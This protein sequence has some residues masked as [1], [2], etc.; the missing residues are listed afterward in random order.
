MARSSKRRAF[1]VLLLLLA[2]VNRNVARAQDFTS[3]NLNLSSSFGRKLQGLGEKFND[4]DGIS[5]DYVPHPNGTPVL[6]EDQDGTFMVGKIKRYD[7]SSRT[8]TIQWDEDDMQEDF[9]DVKKVDNL[10]D[11]AEKN[12]SQE[13]EEKDGNEDYFPMNSSREQEEE[14]SDVKQAISGPQSHSQVDMDYSYN[15]NDLSSYQAYPTGTSA[16]L[17]FADGWYQGKITDFALSAD[18][19]NATY[20]ITWSDGTTDIFVNELEWMDLIVTNAENYTPWEIGTPAYGYPNPT[21]VDTSDSKEFESAYLSGEVTAFENGRYTITWSNG[22]SVFYSDFD[23]VDELVNN[24]G[25]HLDP[26]WM[27]GYNPWP[28]GTPVSWDFDDGWWDGTITDYVAGTYEVTWSDGSSKYYSNVEKIDQMVA[29]ASGEGFGSEEASN[30]DNYYANDDNMY[31]DY[32]ELETVVYAEFEDGWW[33]G[34]IDSFEDEYY[35]IRWSDDS[36]DKFLPGDEMDDM[37]MNAQYIPYDY[38]IY[39]VGTHVRKKFDDTWYTGT[40]EYSEGGFY[41]ILWDDGTRTTY[42]SGNEI[43]EMVTNAYKIGMSLP[44]KIILCLFVIFFLGG[45]AFY[46]L[47]DNIRKNQLTDVT[48]SVRENELIMSQNDAGFSDQQPLPGVQASVV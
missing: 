13:K 2:T 46:S 47:K 28:K 8:Y 25:L 39:G 32:Y 20:T 44:G 14:N 22:D 45:V 4:S 7:S 33:A 29:F 15:Y 34:Y 40:I 17:E 21:A 30:G 24:A 35:V 27:G 38:G 36:I 23:M 26:N 6:C 43:D 12:I 48:E 31:H 16:L 37:V 41:T 11:N 42:V 10:V 18:K 1:L 19:K 5:N 3:R 9:S